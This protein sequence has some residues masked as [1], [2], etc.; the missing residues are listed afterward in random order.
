VQ[1]ERRDRGRVRVPENAEDAALLAQPVA[2]EIERGLAR[3]LFIVVVAFIFFNWLVP[4]KSQPGW[5]TT[6]K[7]LVV[8]KATGERLKGLFPEDVDTYLSKWLHKRPKGDEQEQ[9]ENPTDRHSQ[10]DQPAAG[11]ETGIAQGLGNRAL[12]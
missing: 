2:V 12:R 1:A 5:V 11:G 7:S 6:A 8:L 9:P 10:L 4:E 3:G